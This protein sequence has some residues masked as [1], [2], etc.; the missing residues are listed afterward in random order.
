MSNWTKATRPTLYLSGPMSGCAE[1]N[2]PA[3]RAAVD[4]LRADGV[5]VLSPHE[6]DHQE[7]NGPGSLPWSVYLRNDI[8]CLLRCEGIVL[9]PGWPT[10]RGAQL[11]LQTAL[12]LRMPVFFYRNGELVSMQNEE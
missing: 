7:P 12:A 11:E 5:S 2:F 9:L 6:V 10:S 3:F 8:K 4:R 1:F